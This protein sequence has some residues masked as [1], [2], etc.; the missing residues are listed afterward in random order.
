MK[1]EL[2][3]LDLSNCNTNVPSP[4]SSPLTH[5]SPEN[6]GSVCGVIIQNLWGY[7]VDHNDIFIS[8]LPAAHVYEFAME[9]FLASLGAKIGFYQV[10]FL[11][12]SS[13][14]SRPPSDNIFMTCLGMRRII[15]PF[16]HG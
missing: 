11:C 14:N 4:N 7:P 10:S 15:M 3:R 12:F 13:P 2:L 9:C 8:Y 16:P 1:T 6:I 5:L